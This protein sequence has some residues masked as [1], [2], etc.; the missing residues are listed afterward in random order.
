LQQTWGEKGLSIIGVTD[1]PKGD[2]EKWIE[3]K[4]AKYAYGYDKGGALARFFGVAGIPHVALIDA[5]GVIVYAG[6]AGGY[7]QEQLR[8]ATA[9]SVPK[10]LWEWPA[11]AKAVKGALLKKQY[12]SALDES[13]KVSEADGGPAIKTAIE[14]MV[15]AKVGL[16]KSAHAK[17]DFLGAQDMAEDFH[18]EFVGLPEQADADKMSDDIEADEKAADVI[19]LQKQIQKIR[20]RAPTKRKDVEK[21][22]ED[23]KKI[24]KNGS[25]TYAA[26][27]AET[28]AFQLRADLNKKK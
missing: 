10:P 28:L 26:T 1:E 3:T 11:S 15:R 9:G 8:Q 20:E 18:E 16:M 21:A 23:L 2:T 27:E 19:K 5:N 22:I 4:G 6:G 13:E 14:G 7:T 24:Q 17:G 25:G 12:K